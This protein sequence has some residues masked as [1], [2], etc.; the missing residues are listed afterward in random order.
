MSFT[1]AFNHGTANNG[2]FISMNDTV[3]AINYSYTYDQLNRLASASTASW[4]QGFSYDIWANLYTVTANNAPALSLSF[5]ARQR[6]RCQEPFID[7]PP[8]A[9]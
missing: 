4:S 2:N 3:Q 6:K 5:T 8:G 1:Y 9:W 7:P